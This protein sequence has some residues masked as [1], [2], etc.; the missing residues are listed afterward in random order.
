MS[1]RQ[2]IESFLQ[3]KRIAMV[4]VSTDPRH[5]S[6]SLYRDLQARDYDVIPVNPKAAEIAGHPCYK[7]VRDIAPAPAAALIITPAMQTD[8]V[9]RDC[10]LAGVKRVWMYRGAGTGA[11]SGTAIRFCHDNGIHLV[12]GECPYMFLPDAGFPHN[13]HGWLRKA[14]HPELR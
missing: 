9:V 11:V 4:G 6:R 10:L 5:F 12:A 7:S 14:L 2:E 1:V 8:A 3:E 13:A